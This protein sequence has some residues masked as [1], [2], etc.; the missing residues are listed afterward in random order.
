MPRR[1]PALAAV[2]RGP[3]S[4]F[5]RGPAAAP[6]RDG[7]RSGDLYRYVGPQG[8]LARTGPDRVLKPEDRDAGRAKDSDRYKV[9]NCTW[10]QPVFH[11]FGSLARGKVISV[12]VLNVGFR[13]L[14]Q[15]TRD[16]EADV[17]LPALIVDAGPDAV[18]RFLEFFAGRIANERTRAAYGRAAGQFLAWCEARGLGLGGCGFTR[19]AERDTTCGPPPARRGPRCLPPSSAGSRTGGGEADREGVD[20]AGCPRHDQASGGGRGVPSLDLLPHVPERRGTAYLSNGGTLEPAQQIAGHA[21]LHDDEALRP[22]G[23]QR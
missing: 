22:D 14:P 17:V 3:S 18:Q 12:T 6:A 16:G 11:R 23:G 10:A 19:R 1:S 21:S 7:I 2:Q 5:E 4:A 9:V 8:E 13:P 20:A 15:T